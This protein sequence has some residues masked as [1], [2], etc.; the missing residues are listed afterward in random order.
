LYTVYSIGGPELETTGAE[1]ITGE[2]IAGID[3]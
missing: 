1:T 2:A 3:G